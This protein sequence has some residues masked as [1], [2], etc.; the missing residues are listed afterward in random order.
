MKTL[1]VNT[2]NKI[3]SRRDTHAPTLANLWI[4][5]FTIETVG[6]IVL[7]PSDTSRTVVDEVDISEEHYFERLAESSF[8]ELWDNDDDSIYDT[9]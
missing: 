1:S 4:S 9:L 7:S 6:K 8:A 3:V 5:D 2:E